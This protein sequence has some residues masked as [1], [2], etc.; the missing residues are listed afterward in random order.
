MN[1]DFGNCLWFLIQKNTDAYDL[2]KELQDAVSDFKYS[3]HI[4]IE[5]DMSNN[6]QHCID[7]W[8]K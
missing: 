6:E 3:P 5:Y 1:L 7:K 8:K 2:C 4:T